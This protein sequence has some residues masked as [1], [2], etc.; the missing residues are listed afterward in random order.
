MA[1]PFQIMKSI[2]VKFENS[3]K[4]SKPAECGLFIASIN[5][6]SQAAGSNRT[7]G[8]ELPLSLVVPRHQEGKRERPLFRL[9]ALR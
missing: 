4:T 8:S 2:I 5:T 9:A 7:G 1:I 3:T 6:L